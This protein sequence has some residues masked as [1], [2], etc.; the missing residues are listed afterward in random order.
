MKDLKSYQEKFYA[1]RIGKVYGTWRVIGVR[2]DEIKKTQIW[3]IECVNCGKVRETSHGKELRKGKWG[4]RC[5]CMKKVVAKKPSYEEMAKSHIGEIHNGKRIIAWEK[6]KGYVLKC[7]KC[8]CLTNDKVQKTLE[9]KISR[10]HCENVAKYNESYVG[11]RYGHLVVEKID[12]KL[13]NGKNK[14]IF[15]CK[16]DCGGI[17]EVRPI[18]LEKGY[19]LCCGVKCPYKYENNKT[20]NGISK[21]RLYNI[22]KGMIYRCE[23]TKTANYK[24][25]GGRGIK[26]CDEWHD[27]SKFKEWALA[28]GYADNLTIDRI[29][30]DGNYEP[31]NCRFITLAEN[32]S[33][34]RPK[35][36]VRPEL[37]KK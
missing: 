2:Y 11:K 31:L 35:Y 17:K 26:V 5:D 22:H 6:N 19:V 34:A 24:K 28:N 33:R 29:D 30:P 12:K 14:R 7:E 37:R 21:E 27:Y 32:S 13:I 36:S 4:T 1:K 10:C 23:N 9:N 18:L 20:K 15:I 25:Y 8:G 16:C 3:K